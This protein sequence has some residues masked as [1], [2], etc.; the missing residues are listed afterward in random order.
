MQKKNVFS[1]DFNNDGI[2]D[3][4]IHD[5]D[6]KY[7]TILLGSPDGKF[8]GG[9][10]NTNL[11]IGTWLSFADFNGDGYVDIYNQKSK[12]RYLN[13]GKWHDSYSE[14]F[15]EDYNFQPDLDKD[16]LVFG[17]FNGDSAVDIAD[18][19]HK[20]IL[21]GNVHKSYI[22]KITDSFANRTS[23]T[24]KPLTDKK[25]YSKRNDAN[26]P[27]IDL[28]SSNYVVA[29]ITT[30]NNN[31]TVEDLKYSYI[32]LKYDLKGRGS[33]GFDTIYENDIIHK[34]VTQT[35]YQQSFPFTGIL[36]SET[37]TYRDTTTSA[38]LYGYTS[39][40]D[41]V[42]QIHLTKEIQTDYLHNT[43]TQKTYRYDK[44]GNHLPTGKQYRHTHNGQNCQ[45]HPKHLRKRP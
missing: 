43:R 25:V 20:K 13:T 21:F 5:G 17:D 30:S 11:D 19:N 26:Y 23:I 10:I 34:R 41:K 12:K 4:Y 36:T 42:K 31:Q 15:A 38:T 1:A 14:K 45:N 44:Y 32:G 29:H 9:T 18:T 33:L 16:Y 35:Y 7:D 40:G 6:G 8:T 24:Y 3:L 22:T 39:S 28:R 2:T 37:I 27:A